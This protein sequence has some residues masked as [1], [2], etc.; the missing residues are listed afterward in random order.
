[1]LQSSNTPIEPGFELL[2]WLPAEMRTALLEGDFVEK[3]QLHGELSRFLEILEAVNASSFIIAS[4]LIDQAI[5]GSEFSAELFLLKALTKALMGDHPGVLD[6]IQKAISFG[7]EDI[8]LFIKNDELLASIISNSPQSPNSEMFSSENNSSKAGRLHKPNNESSNIN[9]DPSSSGVDPSLPFAFH[10]K[11][12]GN[13]P[14]LEGSIASGSL[15]VGN[16]ISRTILN[17][18]RCS[19]DG[20]PYGSGHIANASILSQSRTNAIEVGHQLHHSKLKHDFSIGF[21]RRN[22]H[23]LEK[24]FCFDPWKPNAGEDFLLLLVE[25]LR[26]WPRDQLTSELYCSGYTALKKYFDNPLNNAHWV[27]KS[28]SVFAELSPPDFYQKGAVFSFCETK[29]HVFGGEEMVRACE[30]L[31][32]RRVSV[33]DYKPDVISPDIIKKCVDMA[34]SAPSACNR[35]PFNFLLLANAEKRDE[36][37]KLAPGSRG[38]A[39][40]APYVAAFVADYSSFEQKYDHGLALIDASLFS[41]YLQIAFSSHGIGSCCLNWPDKDQLHSPAGNILGLGSHQTVVMLMAFGYP[42]ASGLIPRSIKKKSD[43]IINVIV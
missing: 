33:R 36:V 19:N 18:N 16:Q 13:T 23:R 8:E 9:F 12:Y 24:S 31:F 40:K 30:A 4:D 38:W 39:N 3:P 34:S 26:S 29:T 10:G 25:Q 2:K 22:I 17:Q 6:C 15:D 28:L 5:E 27:K 41:A 37:L 11:A 21:I 43:E 35:Q 14:D 1:M 42:T 32:D 7:Y 20:S